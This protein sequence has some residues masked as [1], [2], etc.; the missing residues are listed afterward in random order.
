MQ[1]FIADT[2]SFRSI[3]TPLA[4][5]RE[6]QSGHTWSLPGPQDIWAGS[7]LKWSPPYATSP[8]VAKPVWFH[9]RQAHP[10]RAAAGR[11]DFIAIMRKDP[12]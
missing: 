1:I 8:D 2:E 11:A 7:R 6:A 9:R 5:M 12:P 10:E 3:K 4:M